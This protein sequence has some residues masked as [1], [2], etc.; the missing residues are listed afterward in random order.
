MASLS[1]L[2]QA[3]YKFNCG[4]KQNKNQIKLRNS[5]EWMVIGRF[6]Q[7]KFSLRKARKQISY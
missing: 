5:T 2:L 4:G 3:S 1:I 7:A 6:D